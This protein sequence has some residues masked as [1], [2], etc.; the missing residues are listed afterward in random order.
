MRQV[1]EGRKCKCGATV[2]TL[3]VVWGE[4]VMMTVPYDACAACIEAE[5]GERE[6]E[7]RR[8]VRQSLLRD[9]ESASTKDERLAHVTFQT[10]GVG[11]HN[12]KAFGLAKQWCEKGGLNNLFI[13]GPIGCGKTYLAR[14]MRNDLTRQEVPTM[15]MNVT[16]LVDGAKL[17]FHDREAKE[18][19]RKARELARTAPVLFLDDLGKSKGGGDGGWLEELLYAIVDPRY[20]HELPTVVTTE[21]RGTDLEERSGKSVVSR[22]NHGC[23]LLGI[24]EPATPYRRPA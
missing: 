7:H 13:H 23:W 19:A 15:W 21:W 17:A 5:D 12:R 22:L 3:S 11:P 14:C 2:Y 20:R 18:A 1:D 24:T 6:Q 10:F 16:D 9:L 8:I 4:R